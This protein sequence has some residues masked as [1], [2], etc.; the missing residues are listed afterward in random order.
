MLNAPAS[1]P[2]RL[3]QGL[4][5]VK[6]L[7]CQSSAA[8]QVVTGDEAATS[9]AVVRCML[10]YPVTTMGLRQ[11]AAEWLPEFAAAAPAAHRWAFERI[12]QPLLVAEHAGGDQEQMALCNHFIDTLHFSEVG[13]GGW[14]GDGL[15]LGGD[16]WGACLPSVCAWGRCAT[17]F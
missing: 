17:T 9:E 16:E 14:V 15:P 8:V 4:L 7:A 12:V 2:P 13:R 6:Q 10:L 5:L 3:A 1:L 11:L